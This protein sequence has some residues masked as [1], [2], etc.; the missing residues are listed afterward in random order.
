[1]H[2]IDVRTLT[3]RFVGCQIKIHYRGLH[4][5]LKSYYFDKRCAVCDN[6][7]MQM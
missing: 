6:I 5:G 7:R 4:L 2:S 3:K 1:M